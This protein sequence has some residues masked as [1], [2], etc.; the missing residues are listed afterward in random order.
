MIR[1]LTED[2]EATLWIAGDLTDEWAAFLERE[3]A[4]RLDATPEL[5]LDLSELKRVD[6]AGLEA[7]RRLKQRGVRI[8]RCS[9]VVAEL[10]GGCGC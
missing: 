6:E 10:V 7:L 2:G 9:R 3:C 8:T 4:L 5:R 1:I